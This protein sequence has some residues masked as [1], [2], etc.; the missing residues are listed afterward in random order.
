MLETT[1]CHVFL[2]VESSEIF[3]HETEEPN[4]D[5]HARGTR[6]LD[7][8]LELPLQPRKNPL[9][10]KISSLANSEFCSDDDA[11]SVLPPDT[12]TPSH[13]RNP[14]HHPQ[15]AR[16]RAAAKFSHARRSPRVAAPSTQ[17]LPHPPHPPFSHPPPQRYTLLIQ[18]FHIRSCGSTRHRSNHNSHYS[19]SL[20]LWRTL[21]LFVMSSSSSRRVR[22]FSRTKQRNQ[23]RI[24][25]LTPLEQ[26]RLSSRLFHRINE[27]LRPTSAT[28]RKRNIS[29]RLRKPGFSRTISFDFLPASRPSPLLIRR[30]PLHRRPSPHRRAN[31]RCVGIAH[32][33]RFVRHGE[34]EVRETTHDET[35]DGSVLRRH[36]Q[37]WIMIICGRECPR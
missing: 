35:H 10:Q 32:I 20:S 4:S 15:T 2:L 3:T 24:F 22:R 17:R 7:L 28:S 26:N 25:I 30:L 29:Y 33:R 6:N 31:M 1:I 16:A 9:P 12:D 19:R 14:D 34:V 36:L 37:L 13:E 27:I 23:I 21:R 8:D 18:N 11:T 5:F